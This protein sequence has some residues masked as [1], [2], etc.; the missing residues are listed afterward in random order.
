M[1]STSCQAGV[2]TA[3]GEVAKDTQYQDDVS[4]DGGD[5]V[6]LVC[7]TLVFGHHDYVLSI[8][9]SIADATI[10]KKWFAV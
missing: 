2:A 3:A 6:P 7:E 5:V 4:A 9:N 10:V 1:S 8:L